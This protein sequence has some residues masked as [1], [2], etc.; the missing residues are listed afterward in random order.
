MEYSKEMNIWER[1][2]AISAEI[3]S[4]EKSTEV[5]S[6]NN[7]YKAAVEADVLRPVKELEQKYRVV[8]FPVDRGI[9]YQGEL[10]KER[11]YEDKNRNTVTTD[12][13]KTP[14]IRLSVRLRFVNLDN[15]SDF[16][17]T[18]S[19]GDGVDSLDKA[20]GKAMTYSDK[21]GLMKAY[22]M[23]TGDDPDQNASD[24]LEGHDIHKIKE[25]FDRLMT[26][27]IKGGRSEDEIISAMGI[28]RKQFEVYMKSFQNV[29]AIED[30]LRR[31]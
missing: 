10:T 15:P 5:G 27:K 25:R 7:R 28:T 11:R 29:A 1:V 26:Q 17:E 23:L 18:V 13:T 19:Y 22:K 30:R 3:K 4:V 2:S 6:G 14:I 31:A 9:V 8:S 12:I 21:Y 24:E 20:P 16:I